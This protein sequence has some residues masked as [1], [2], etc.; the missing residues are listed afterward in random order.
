MRIDAGGNVGIGGTPT[1]KLD[2]FSSNIRMSDTFSLAWGD[3]T[4]YIN[5]SAA[6]D[7]I[8]VNTNSTERVRFD[9]S[10]NVGIGA[11]TPVYQLQ[12]KG[13][14]QAAA[15]PT[16][17]GNKGGSLYLQDTIGGFG[18]GGTLLFGTTLG[19]STPLAAIKGYVTDGSTN[20]VGDLIFSTRNAIT[21]TSLTERLRITNTGTIQDGGGL[22]LGYRNIPRVTGGIERGKMYATAAGFTLNTGTAAGGAYSVYND[23][24]SA[25]T[26]TQGAGLTLRLTGTTN[27]GNRTIAAR[28]IA[29][30][31]FN[32]TT[33]AAMSGPGVS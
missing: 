27:T 6:T 10:G 12:V 21:D 28:G 22:E 9:A 33:E 4:T 15:A 18:N 16:D 30:I 23:S 26:V 11:T 3:S 5:G 17:A 14:T 13:A 29:T 31:W 2:V 7:I 1:V 19:N 20:T 24:A 32:S 25:I 8:T